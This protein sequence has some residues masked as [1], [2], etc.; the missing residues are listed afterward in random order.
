MSVDIAAVDVDGM[1]REGRELA[2]LAD[3]LV[4][5]IPMIEEG[6]IALRRLSA[7]GIRVSTTLVFT[8]AQ[9]LLA[10]KAGAA[11]V[12]PF[13]SRLDD[14]G[15]DTLTVIRDIR[16]VFDSARVE[17][18]IIGAAVSSAFHFTQC[19]KIGIDIAAVSPSV[20]R[21]LLVHPLTDRGLD[22]L[23]SDW[24]RRMARARTGE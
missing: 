22:E 14:L 18:E 23:L 2:R 17:C 15:H 3:N 24:S 5:R 19:A 4:I 13:V 8:A 1:Y 6:I 9:A 11:Y 16:E 10:A 21:G 7:D 20:L 12:S